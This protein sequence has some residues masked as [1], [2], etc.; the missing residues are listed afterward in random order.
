MSKKTL[1]SK[2]Q[3]QDIEQLQRQIITL[4][5]ELLTERITRIDFQTQLLMQWRQRCQQELNHL[6]AGEE[7]CRILEDSHG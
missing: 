7:N 5:R 6:P 3:V 2:D 4:T 1:T